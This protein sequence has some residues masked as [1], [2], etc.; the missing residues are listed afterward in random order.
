MLLEQ[1]ETPPEPTS[2]VPF[3]RDPDFVERGDLLDQIRV[4]IS[5]PAARVALVGLGGIGYGLGESDGPN[6]TNWRPASRNSP[7]STAIV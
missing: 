4:K 1:A 2:N 6:K 7:S 3:R 5:Q